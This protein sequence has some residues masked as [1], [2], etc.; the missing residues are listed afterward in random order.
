MDRA[1][2]VLADLIAIFTPAILVVATQLE[3]L[4]S[5]K[6][7]QWASVAAAALGAIV[8]WARTATGGLRSEP[9]KPVKFN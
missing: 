8:T 6:G 4:E 7:V 3:N 1:K 9:T 5:F 2:A